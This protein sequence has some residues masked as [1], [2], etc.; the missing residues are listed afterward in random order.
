MLQQLSHKEGCINAQQGI[1]SKQQSGCKTN[2]I[3]KTKWKRLRGCNS[4]SSLCV[5][6]AFCK[7]AIRSWSSICLLYTGRTRFSSSDKG[8]YKVFFLLHGNREFSAVTGI[9]RIVFLRNRSLKTKIFSFLLLYAR[10]WRNQ[11]A[12]NTTFFKEVA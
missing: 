10:R 11:L 12:Y 6:K 1:A 7:R 2:S 9:G 8:F 3:A 5:W 4:C